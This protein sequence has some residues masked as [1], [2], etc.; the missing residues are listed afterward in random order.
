MNRFITFFIFLFCANFYA[1]E[2]T[3]LDYELNLPISNC[4]I[5]NESKLKVVHTDK[6][7]KGDISIFKENEILSFNHISFV[8]IEVLKRELKEGKS[9]VFLHRK[10]EALDE[11]IL[12]TSRQKVTRIRIAEHVEIMQQKD[13][14]RSASQTSAD[15]LASIPGI[16]VQKSQFG[17]G[18]P[19][20]RGM[21]ANR[22]L[23]VVDGVRMNNAI[24]RSGHLQS[25]ISVS[26]SVLERTE[27]V[28]G[29]S[30]VI[31]GSDALGGVIH[32]YT[33]TPKTGLDK[34][35]NVDFMTRFGTV[36]NESTQ[37]GS[38][39]LSFKK[40]GSLTSFSH[41]DFG[42]LRMGN[43]RRHGYEDWGKVFD[44]SLNT[45]S[46]Y[47]ANST[48]N[49][50]LNIQKNT[51]YNQSDLLQK[52][53]F[54][55][56]DRANLTFNIQYSTSSD[57][58]R[59]DKLTERSSGELKF[60][61]WYYGPQKRFL[62]SSQ[63]SIRPGKKWMNNGTITGA[64]QNIIESRVQRK[65]TS[66]DRS[67]RNEMVDVYSLNGD[68]SVQLGT[69]S[70]RKL[71]YG[72][73]IT[74][75][76]VKS[77]STGKTLDVD[78]NTIIGFAN[79]FIVQS[80]YPD[81]GSSYD[82]FSGYVSYRQD[83]TPKSTLNTGVR[84]TY[85]NLK[86]RWIDDT[87]IAL[88]SS[89]ISIDNGAI[90]ATAGYAYR[91]NRNWQLNAVISSG[92]RSPNIDDV[93]KIREK[94]GQVTVPNI[95]LRPEYSY[96]AEIGVLKYLNDKKFNL[97]L[98]IYY[99]L[100]DKY[101]SREQFS[102]GGDSSIIYDGEEVETYANVNNDNAY[103]AGTTF[104]FGGKV[105]DNLKINGSITYTKGE[106]TD[107]NLPLSSIPPIFGDL[108]V[109]FAKN[110]FEVALNF[111][112]NG[113]KEL[114]EYNLVEGIDNIEQSPFN[115]S[116]QKHLGTPSWNTFNFYSKHKISKALSLQVNI[117]NIFDI[118]YK[119]FASGISSAGRNFSLS[120]FF[121]N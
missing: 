84:Y 98:N 113:S 41:S 19:V 45:D 43:K 114:N 44:Y 94:N 33:K 8:E 38:V 7:G 66:L 72:V 48:Q 57:I 93:G 20:L 3:V 92:F 16:K 71:S 116:T 23:L 56:S 49:S 108:E 52:F 12:S 74:H 60:S 100:L 15:L 78:G 67:Y 6:N 18:S 28:F 79:D 90:T 31:Y 35:M 106:S 17:G 9:T 50:N 96:S 39:E 27:V 55:F 88:P 46:Y 63:L 99:S 115:T 21:E 117:D 25:S 81:G 91:P 119:E 102:L 103:I 83:V 30:S 37:Q 2:I 107:T 109:L 59:F 75:N 40:W 82:S 42:D 104:S 85:T 77:G 10:A 54:G 86:A 73:E 112:F 47:S 64:Y 101:I 32:Y 105:I 76:Y 89:D 95:Q 34:M 80:R 11:V 111:R 61:E 1:Q 4:T 118:H 14:A 69:T 87:Y 68:F 13:I 26:P 121:N 5:Y 110:R 53:Y 97:G 29:P 36:N 62:V 51:G 65:F 24:Y 58:P 22:I 70:N 120:L